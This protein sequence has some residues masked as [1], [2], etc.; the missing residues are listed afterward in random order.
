M[1]IEYDTR[2][3]L[4]KCIDNLNLLFRRIKSLCFF[5]KF[6]FNGLIEI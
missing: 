2:F 4:L 5:L 6:I 1:S 3:Y